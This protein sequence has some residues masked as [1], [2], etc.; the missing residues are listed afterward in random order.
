MNVLK[1][2]NVP[3]FIISLAI[4]LF[5]VYLSMEDGRKILVYPTPENA[6]VIQYKDSAGN[7]FQIKQAGVACPK[8]D[9]DI[10]KIP[11]QS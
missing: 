7:C 11:A 9:A 2:I 4:G 8:N 3:V 10:S 1:Y 5:I 6:D